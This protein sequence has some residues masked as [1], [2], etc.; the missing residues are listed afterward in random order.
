L[1]PIYLA[2]LAAVG[3]G[4]VSG[5]A[6]AWW[7]I[8][9]PDPTLSAA[10]IEPSWRV[11]GRVRRLMRFGLVVVAEPPAVGRVFAEPTDDGK[12]LLAALDLPVREAAP[13]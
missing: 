8:G 7:Y 11:T 12:A 2:V 13:C 10:R 9:E 4:D 1:N 5:E 3:R 6:S